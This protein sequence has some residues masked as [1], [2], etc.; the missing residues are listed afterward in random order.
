MRDGRQLEVLL[1]HLA[2]WAAELRE[3]S[4]RDPD[5]ED[6][7]A[8]ARYIFQVAGE[9]PSEL[10][11][12][13]IAE[14]APELEETMATVEEQLIQK[15]REQGLEQGLEQGREQGRALALRETLLRLLR[16][17]FGA[18]DPAIEKRIAAASAAE[19]DR[20]IERV[21]TAASPDDVFE[22]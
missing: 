4:G 12:Q 10:V 15:G 16:A 17:R 13:R 11:R 6:R 7:A 14:A 21:L 1:A 8:L 18:P 22:P 9:T 19:L 20:W 2:T 3:L 5:H